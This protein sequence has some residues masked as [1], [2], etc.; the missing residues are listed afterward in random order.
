MC[1]EDTLKG[2]GGGEKGGT[3]KETVKI[4]ETLNGNCYKSVYRI[5]R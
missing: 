4:N 2:G 5:A 1:R 3:D